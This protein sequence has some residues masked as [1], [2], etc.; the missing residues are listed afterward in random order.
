MYE[1]GRLSN[2]V[3]A[4]C[5]RMNEQGAAPHGVGATYAPV[6]TGPLSKYSCLW[7]GFVKNSLANDSTSVGCS[8]RAASTNLS[9]S[10]LS[11]G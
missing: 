3:I 7:V 2:K 1:R 4:A 8:S 10:H 6:P 11:S 5:T 9:T